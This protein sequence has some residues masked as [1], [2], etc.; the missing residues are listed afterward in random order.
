M[1]MQKMMVWAALLLIAGCATGYREVLPGV[2]TYGSMR[3]T[4]G[5]AW[6]SVPNGHT[7]MSRSDTRTWTKDGVLL[8]R[9]TIFP[10]VKSGEAIF[11]SRNAS[12]AL[13]SFAADMLPNEIEELVESSIMK[14]YGEGNAS[15]STSNLR[16]QQ[17]GELG[18]F[19]F[20][21]EAA[22]TES[23][24]YH[25]MVGGFIDDDRLYLTIYLAAQPHYFDKYKEEADKIIKSSSV[26]QR[27][28]RQ[29]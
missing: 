13:P 17:Y 29:Y 23:P 5:D 24:D 28:I 16:P 3:I 22:V 6:N 1:K 27:T 8:D 10:G 19:M 4:A 7:P 9:I 20:D 21:I 25:G 18:G 15:V 12:A 26:A 14:L 11:D 2:Q